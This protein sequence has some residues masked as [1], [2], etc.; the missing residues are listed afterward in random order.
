MSRSGW[1]T[2]SPDRLNQLLNNQSWD[3][4]QMFGGARRP[5]PAPP[6][7][8][9]VEQAQSARAALGGRRPK[10]DGHIHVEP[11]PKPTTT[12][13]GFSA[14]A[15]CVLPRQPCATRLAVHRG[16]ELVEVVPLGLQASFVAGRSPDAD[17]VLEHPS[18]SRRHAAVLHH[19]SGAVYLLDLGSA[20][21]TFLGG[22]RLP[23]HEPTLWADGV[24]CIF[25][26]SSRSYVLL[27]GS[28]S[29]APA[30][31]AP[32]LPPSRAERE[33]GVGRPQAQ[34]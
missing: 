14:P 8:Q 19:R 1:R 13:L 9:P 2:G 16:S 30:P 25:G 7:P 26:A 32:A 12:V 22:Q 28:L 27:L 10:G 4:S 20:H 6:P 11:I 34:G 33:G 3:P 31:R 29:S 21:G 24:S 15:W 5:A 18:A 23:Q 17:V